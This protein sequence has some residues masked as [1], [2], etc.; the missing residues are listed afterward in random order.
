LKQLGAGVS[1]DVFLA[2]PE[3]ER[4]GLPSPLVIKRLHPDL[5]DDRA[6]SARFKQE[7]QI[8]GAIQSPNVARVYDA[9]RVEDTFYIA[10][11]Y[12]AACTLSRVLADLRDAG[13][14]ATL[15]SIRDILSDA[16]EG[17]HALHTAVDPKTSQPL[18]VVHRDLAPKN[19]ILGEDSVTRLIDLGI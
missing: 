14:P 2:R 5:A 7:A 8:A 19:I 11:E 12:V 15:S 18:F 9:G 6:F 1:G 17:L 13:A 4:P 16:L 3:E 10:M